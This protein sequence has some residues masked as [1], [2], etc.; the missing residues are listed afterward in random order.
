V[1]VSL[2]PTNSRHISVG[3]ISRLLLT[4]DAENGKREGPVDPY[5]NGSGEKPRPD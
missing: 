5:V 2:Y 3:G 1:K 4:P